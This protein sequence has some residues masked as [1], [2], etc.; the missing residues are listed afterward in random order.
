V[1]DYFD[2]TPT[3]IIDKIHTWYQSLK[4]SKK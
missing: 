2:L 4:E 3:K 1:I